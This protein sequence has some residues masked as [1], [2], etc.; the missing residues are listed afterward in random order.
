M[1][2]VM[3]ALVIEDEALIGMFIGDLLEEIGFETVSLATTKAEALSLARTTRP[4]FIA[5]DIRLPD[6]TGVEAVREIA[7]A[8]GA[9]PVVYVTANPDEAPKPHSIVCEK[10]VSDRALREAVERAM[11]EARGKLPN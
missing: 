8:L 7:D 1:Q 11:A 3:H 2:D 6:G 5:S 9:T 10:P 4:D